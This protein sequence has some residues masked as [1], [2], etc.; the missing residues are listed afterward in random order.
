MEVFKKVL[1]IIIRVFLIIL[2]TLMIIGVACNLILNI[3]RNNGENRPNIFG[4]A[5]ISIADNKL[6]PDLNEGDFIII[7]NTGNYE[8]GDVITIEKGGEF[9]TQRIVG[10]QYYENRS[11]V[12]QYNLANQTSVT[13]SMVYGEMTLRFAGFAPVVSFFQTIPGVS[14]LIG[15]AV[16][17]IFMP[18]II[19][20]F[21]K[22][23]EDIKKNN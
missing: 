11:D 14:V 13:P 8:I 21:K 10:I 17:I 22:K 15:I 23:E 6:S 2:L 4:L 9:I 18:G 7:S 20:S 5:P 19:G 12:K 1:S 3:Q 16:L